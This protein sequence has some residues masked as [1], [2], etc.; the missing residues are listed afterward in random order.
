MGSR[1]GFHIGIV[2]VVFPDTVLYLVVLLVPHDDGD[3]GGTSISTDLVV[4]A[5]TASDGANGR[6]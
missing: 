3:V 4:A 2:V 5:G 6:G 1:R